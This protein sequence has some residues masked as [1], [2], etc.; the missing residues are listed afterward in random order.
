M[1]GELVFRFGV[2]DKPDVVDGTDPTR[3]FL[4]DS[5]EPLDESLPLR[6]DGDASNM[7]LPGAELGRSTLASRNR[8]TGGAGAAVSEPAA[9]DKLVSLIL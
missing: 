6:P 5:G 1:A 3:D 2:G 8:G 4:N 9:R 7:A